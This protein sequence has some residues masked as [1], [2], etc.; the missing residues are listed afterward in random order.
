MVKHTLFGI[1]EVIRKE[2]TGGNV[3]LTVRFDN[4]KEMRLAIPQSFE[5]GAVEALGTLKD[6]VDQAIAEKKARLAAAVPSPKP[7]APNKKLS[8]KSTLR[9]TTAD[10]YEDYLIKNGYKVESDSGNPSTVSYY[11]RGVESVL[12]E[13]GI[14]WD[15]LKTCISTIVAKY[16]VGGSHELFGAKGN[17]TVICSL[18]RFEDFVNT[19]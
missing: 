16:D 2:T 7:V 13:E 3:R 17:N 5:T 6:E 9:G 8:I 10:A 18:K 14:S 15:T 4:G 11:V 12:T 19:P 1:G